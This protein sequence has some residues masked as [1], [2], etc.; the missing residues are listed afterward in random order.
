MNHDESSITWELPASKTDPHA[1]GCHRTWGCT[2]ASDT[3]PSQACPFHC[4]TSHLAALD[5]HFG[6][7]AS[8]P[9]SPLCP[10][11]DGE[12]VTSD[13][14][15]ELVD[16]LAKRAGE[17]LFTKDGQRRFG[18]H[19]FRS[20]GAVYLSALGIELLK[21]QMLARWA[22]AVITRYTRLAPL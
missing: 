6:S 8:L 17:A 2:C 15:V 1:R 19:S 7:D 12:C 14:I 21:I 13:N 18:K 16:E 22:S 11:I 10:T 3:S 4:M 20:T 9:D 5:Q